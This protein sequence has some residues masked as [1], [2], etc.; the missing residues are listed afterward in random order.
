MARMTRR[1]RGQLDAWVFVREEGLVRDFVGVLP[2]GRRLSAA[3][4]W[5][6][7]WVPFVEGGTLPKGCVALEVCKELRGVAV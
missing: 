2:D 4:M 1:E 5:D 6:S 3:V 7:S